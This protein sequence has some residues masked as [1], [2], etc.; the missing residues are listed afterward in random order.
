MLGSVLR[1]LSAAIEIGVRE[2]HEEETT[3][4]G[5]EE[6]AIDGLKSAVGRGVDVQTSR[7]EE[8]DSFLAWGVCAANGKH[9]CTVTEDTRAVA[10]V[11]ELVLFI[12]LLYAGPGDDITRVDESV[13]EFGR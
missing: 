3:E 10:E 9:L 1:W 13:E 11:A 8:L 4:R 6:G 5:T 12:H 7:A 2:C